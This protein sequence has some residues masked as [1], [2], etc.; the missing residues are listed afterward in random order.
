[1]FF[2]KFS[3]D[4][5]NVGQILDHKKIVYILFD[6]KVRFDSKLSWFDMELPI[7]GM[8]DWDSLDI[9]SVRV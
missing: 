3:P 9:L 2:S 4:V 5:Q 1:M 7:K 6:F 8:A